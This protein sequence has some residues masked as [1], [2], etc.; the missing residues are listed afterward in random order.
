MFIVIIKLIVKG[1]IYIY[2]GRERE[3]RERGRFVHLLAVSR[4]VGGWIG[5]GWVW[6]AG[7]RNGD[8]DRD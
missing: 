1:C 5:D 3:K 8:G 2:I 4:R 6:M 7:G